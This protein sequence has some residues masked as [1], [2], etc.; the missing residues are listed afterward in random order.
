MNFEETFPPNRCEPPSRCA[1]A[2]LSGRLAGFVTELEAA[3]HSVA[4][5]HVEMALCSYLVNSVEQCEAGFDS[6]TAFG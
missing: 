1:L 2:S 3:G 6:L 5:A 4:A